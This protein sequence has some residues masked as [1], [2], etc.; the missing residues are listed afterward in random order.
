MVS[1]SVGADFT[2]VANWQTQLRSHPQTSDLRVTMAFNG[3]GTTA[4]YSAVVGQSDTLII[5]GSTSGPSTDTLTPTAQAL[6]QQFFWVSHTYNHT[7]LDEVP[8]AAA[9]SEIQQNNAAADALG[10]INY[11]RHALVQPDVSGLGNPAF[12]QTAFDNGIRY[13][14]SDTSKPGQDNPSPNVGMWAVS[15]PGIFVIPRRANNC[16]N[17]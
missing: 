8:P 3:V 1:S 12:L 7:N 9:A 13:L 10:L 2:A 11:A 4:G 14:L 5:G 15:Q 6:Q 16:M 17:T